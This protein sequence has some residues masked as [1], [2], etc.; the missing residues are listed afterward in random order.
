MSASACFLS[1]SVTNSHCQ[2]C[3]LLA[4]RRLDGDLQALLDDGAVDGLVEVEPLA[5]GAG[6]GQHF[7][8]GEVQLH[9]RS[10]A[11]RAMLLASGRVRR[12]QPGQ[13][14]QSGPAPCRG[15]RPR[16]LPHGP[17]PPVRCRPLRPAPPRR[18]RRPRRGAPAVPHRHRHPVARPPR[19]ADDRPRLLGAGARRRPPPRRR[20]RGVDRLR[21]ERAVRR[22]GRAR[23]RALRPRVHRASARC[24][25]CRRSTGGRAS[26]PRCCAPAGGCSSARATR[27]CGRWTIRAPTG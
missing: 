19:G 7:V 27:C 23:R 11:S 3:E 26:S 5:H 10:M 4:R 12:D 1:G 8:G 24:A 18:H 21:R 25:G 6:G 17:D 20:H 2:P 22:G 15:L 14:E 16:R 13:L 9:R